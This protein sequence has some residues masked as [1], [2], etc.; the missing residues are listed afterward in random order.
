MPDFVLRD[1]SNNVLS[2]GHARAL[3]TLSN[4]NIKK[5]LSI[6]YHDNLSVR[7]VERLVYSMKKSPSLL[8]EERKMKTLLNC[9]VS[10]SPKTISLRFKTEEER[11][12][13]IHSL[14]RDNV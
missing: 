9:Q 2:F 1:I 6:I 5:T 10:I 14:V 4:E 12:K 8:E 11:E 13:F 7:E 3:S